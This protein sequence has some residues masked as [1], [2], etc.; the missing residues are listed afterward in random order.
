M[1]TLRIEYRPLEQIS[2]ALRNP[3]NHAEQSIAASMSRFGYLEPMLVDERTGRLVAGHGR[4]DELI[5]AR[6]GGGPVPEGV[7]VRKGAWFVPV[8]VGWA[9]AD[10]TDAH[11]AGVALNRIGGAGGWDPEALLGI[12]DRWGEEEDPAALGFDRDGLAD[13]RALAEEAIDFGA[14]GEAGPVEGGIRSIILDYP[15]AEYEKIT[16]LARRLR[17]ERGLDSNAELVEQLV[18]EAA[19]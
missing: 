5:R 10:D 13:L 11:A 9:S 17:D 18:T 19:E 15:L 14:L 3:K 4:R 12:L 1:G 16:A 6:D 2:D 7:Q 8:T